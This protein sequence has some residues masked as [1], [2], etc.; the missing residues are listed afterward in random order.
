MTN[1]LITKSKSKYFKNLGFLIFMLVFSA[2]VNAQTT[3]SGT[4]SDSSGPIPGV[5]IIVKG[6][7][8]NTVSN[9]DGTY[10]IKAPA[11][12]ILVY[13]FIGYKVK[14]VSVAN[15]SKIDVLLEED[16]NNLKEVVVVGYGTMKRGDLT[17][18]VS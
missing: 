4:V 3:V 1:F 5:N 12:A 10:T 13:S 9:F 15:K 2:A 16:L 14:E 8:I 11:T 18:A 6:S 7:N 17:G